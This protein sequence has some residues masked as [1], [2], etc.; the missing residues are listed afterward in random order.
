MSGKIVRDGSKFFGETIAGINSLEG[1]ELDEFEK[2]IGSFT[3]EMFVKAVNL[4]PKEYY[5]MPFVDAVMQCN[6]LF[7]VFEQV[8]EEKMKEEED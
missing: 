3:I 4:I 1:E 6:A 2:K 7:D 8:Y 5:D